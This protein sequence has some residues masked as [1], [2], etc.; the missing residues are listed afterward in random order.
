MSELTTSE[1]PP[2]RID[3]VLALAVAEGL[4]PASATPPVGDTRPWPVVLLTAL[5][6]WFAAVPLLTVV[7]M[8][9]GPLLDN[10][11]GPYV[12]GVLLLIG[13]AVVLRSAS[14]PLFVEQLAVPGL[15]VGGGSLAFGL[16]RD[17]P[18]ALAALLLAGVA[19]GVALH[20]RQAWLRVLLG[21]AMAM[22]VG[23]ALMRPSVWTHGS[24]W[25]PAWVATHVLLLLALGVPWLQGLF[26]SG[27]AAAESLSAGWWVVVFGSL[28]TLAG[29]TFLVGGA[30]GGGAGGELAREVAGSGV[31]RRPLLSY[32]YPLLS[33]VL[34]LGALA[35]VLYRWPGVRRPALAVAGAV[36]V[37]LSWWMSTLG[38]VL[39][40]LAA[41]ATTQRSRLAAVAGVA[42]AWIVGAFYYGLAWPLATKALVLV[43]A[44]ALLGAVAWWEL[45]RGRAAAS[46]TG[47]M[48]ALDRRALALGLGTL[49]TVAVATFAI[50]QKQ[51]LIAQGRPVFVALA[52]VDP[53]SLMQGDF[54]RLNFSL[55]AEIRETSDKTAARPKVVARRDG[56]NVALL[57]RQAREGEALAA[58][59]F[60][61]ELTPKNGEWILVTDAW[62]FREGEGE[63]W[64]AARFGEFRV[65]PDGRALLVGMADEKLQP[66]QP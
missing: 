19:L 47:A 6:A 36:L 13:S 48:P 63:R 27:G 22:L 17:L 31:A 39:L 23:F 2:A 21:V 46:Q 32:S 26:R 35:L 66:I 24:G 65:L 11:A 33:A 41:L 43:G 3:T 5:G 61:F 37:G 30:M 8:L 49:A 42:A 25:A 57:L 18:H 16:F 50:W 9:L 52:P 60:L 15:L 62:F 20:L 38:G 10:S 54:M 1:R 51:E 59:E 29:M 4:L 64:A 40:G 58:D 7:G 55:P 34:A 28:A 56:R 53:R 44:G 45:R 14:V 12:V